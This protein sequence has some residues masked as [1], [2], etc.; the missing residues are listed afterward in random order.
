[1]EDNG[2]M[3]RDLKSWLE[4]S[5]WVMVGMWMGGEDRYVCILGDRNSSS[6]SRRRLE[7]IG[8]MRMRARQYWFNVYDATAIGC[9][10]DLVCRTSYGFN[11]LGAFENGSVDDMRNYIGFFEV[12]RRDRRVEDD[13]RE[14]LGALVREVGR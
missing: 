1:M 12:L 3:F 10:D 5:G 9:N 6:D 7:V 2:V 14:G 8:E 4:S 11:G 13:L